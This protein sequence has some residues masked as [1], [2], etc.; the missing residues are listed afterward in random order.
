M[1]ACLDQTVVIDPLLKT[2]VDVKRKAIVDVVDAASAVDD[3]GE[4]GGV[5]DEVV[6]GDA[7]AV[8][9][10]AVGSVAGIDVA[11]GDAAGIG[12]AAV[13]GAGMAA[14]VDVD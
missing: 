13:V 4:H 11:D 9:A 3:M 14:A 1:N 10:A 6:G 8:G 7:A 5:A 12:V 2:V